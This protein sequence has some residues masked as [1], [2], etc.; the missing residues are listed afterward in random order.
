MAKYS[1]LRIIGAGTFGEVTECQRDTDGERFARKRLLAS[2]DRDGTTR[3]V[4]EARILSKLDHP[5]VIRVIATHLDKPP[6]SF[7]MPLYRGSLEAE[8]PSVFGQHDR[9]AKIFLGILHGMEYA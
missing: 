5:N 9:I 6:H 1:D 4:R 2:A 7:V 3:F 8:L